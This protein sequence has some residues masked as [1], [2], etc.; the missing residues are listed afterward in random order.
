MLNAQSRRRLTGAHEADA[1][2]LFLNTTYARI[3]GVAP[4]E[5]YR[6]LFTVESYGNTLC[7]VYEA[8]RPQDEAPLQAQ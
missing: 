7:A 5:G 4:P 2:Y 8:D 6:E 3:N 1:P